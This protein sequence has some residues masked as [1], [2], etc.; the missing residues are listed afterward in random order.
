MPELI[1]IHKLHISNQIV[2]RRNLSSHQGN[3]ITLLKTA[4]INV[5]SLYKLFVLVIVDYAIGGC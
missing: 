4:Y 1:F 2:T 5:Y 3:C